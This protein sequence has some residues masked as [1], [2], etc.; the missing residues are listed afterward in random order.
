MSE[1]AYAIGVDFGTESARSLLLDLQTGE[2][3]GT[4]V[5]R[6]PHGVIDRTLPE[7]GEQLPP[8]W[9][10]QDPDDWVH[11][12][13]T[14]IANAVRETE[15]RGETVAG[16]G[17]DFTSCTVLPVASD[18]TPMCKLERWRAHRHA[19]PKLWKHHAAQPVADRLNEVALERHEEFIE[20]YGG[21]ISSEWYFP[22]LI[23]LW[24]EHRE[25]YDATYGYI[26]ATD[27][28]VW[29]MTGVE[30]RQ[31]TTAGYKALWSPNTGLPP[32]GFFQAAYPGFD[33]PG[34]KLGNSFVA[35][36]ERAGAL[37]PGL[38]DK[39]GLPSSTP[40]AV[41]NVD[42]FV[43]LPG[44][45]VAEAGTFVSVVGTSICDMVVHPE[46]IRLPGITGVV[47][48][49][50]LPGVYGYEA[51]QV[52]VGDMLAWF[53]QQLA[54][55]GSTHASLERG[56]AGL[57]PGETGLVALDWWNGNRT[58]LA[59]ADLTGVL[60]GLTLHSSPVE[61]YRALLESIA[62]GNRRIVENFTQYGLEL[63][64]IV[65]CGG[66][67]IASPLLMQLFADISGL[68][69]HVPDST[70]VPARGAALF[71]AVAGEA[72]PDIRSAIS[73]TRPR[74]A[75][76][77]APDRDA[78]LVYDRVYAIYAGLHDLLGRSHVELLHDL[79]HI[80]TER[81]AA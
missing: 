61:I 76:T 8:D 14:G 5:V 78:K 34:A 74:T 41:G 15:I 68:E 31:R 39:V 18:G 7:T 27:W 1:P 6:Y 58:V 63:T 46:E 48:E 59:D 54:P 36:G 22:K 4:S 21:R 60:C 57:R 62:F 71:G 45:G 42:S 40:V 56:A 43:S 23:E 72:F 77:Y 25:L 75:T 80:R 38:A 16:I 70:E 44:A 64:N 32:V 66:V 52:A 2:Q 3:L 67:A 12:L 11:A 47:W 50:I 20:R 9:A 33:Q 28:I 13:E 29:H 37:R 53:V 81:R 65:A 55:P 26:E 19:W 79:K 10:L 69:V 35:L 73:A 24:L 30:R 49:G 17:V 51:G